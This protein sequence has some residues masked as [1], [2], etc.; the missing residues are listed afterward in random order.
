MQY[1]LRVYKSP[2]SRP[3]SCW[4]QEFYTVLLTPFQGYE[5]FSLE[6]YLKNFQED[7]DE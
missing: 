5:L 7:Q 3:T 4:T 6:L 2:S 1:F